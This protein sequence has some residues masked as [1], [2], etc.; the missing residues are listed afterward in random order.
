MSRWQKG[1]LQEMYEEACVTG[2]TKRKSKNNFR[3]SFRLCTL[4]RYSDA[5]RAL[6]EEEFCVDDESFES[7]CNLHPSKPDGVQTRELSTPLIITSTSIIKDCL[8]S[9]PKGSAPGLDGYRAEHILNAI[10]TVQN[11]SVLESLMALLNIIL[12]GRIHPEVKEWFAGGKLCALKKSDGGIRPI[13]MGSVVRRLTSKIVCRIY[14]QKFTEFLAPTQLG[15]GVKSG[16]ECL[17]HEVDLV[18]RAHQ[19]DKNFVIL[20]IDYRNAFNLV[21]RQVFLDSIHDNFPELYNYVVSMYGVQAILTFGSKCIR[22][23]EGTQQGDPMGPVLFSLAL[24]IVTDKLKKKLPKLTMNRWYLDDGYIGSKVKEVISAFKIVRDVGESV[25]LHLRIEKCELFYPAGEPVKLDSFPSKVKLIKDG[26]EVIGA[27]IGSE[28]FSNAFFNHQYTELKSLLQRLKDASSYLGTQSTFIL[29]SKCISFCR[30]VFHARTVHPSLLRTHTDNYDKLVQDCFSLLIPGLTE[31][32]LIQCSLP[33]REGGLGLRRLS[34]HLLPA[35]I[36]SAADAI[37]FMNIEETSVEDYWSLKQLLDCYNAAA[38]TKLTWKEINSQKLLSASIDQ[39][40]LSEFSSTL[41]GTDKH[42][43]RA[44]QGSLSSLWLSAVPTFRNQ[45]TSSE[46]ETCVK[47]RLGCT[48]FKDQFTCNF[49]GGNRAV[50]CRGHHALVCRGGGDRISRHNVIRDLLADICT[51]ASISP[52]SIV[53]EKKHLLDD[54]GARPADVFIPAWNEGRGLCLDITVSSPLQSV[55]SSNYTLGIAAIKAAE[56]KDRKYKD[57][58]TSKGI[59]FMPFSIESFGVM[60][61]RAEAFLNKVVTRL[62]T[63]SELNFSIVKAD[64]F[65]RVSIALHRSVAR[66]VLKRNKDSLTVYHAVDSR[67]LDTVFPLAQSLSLS[68]GITSS[69]SFISD[70]PSSSP[71]ASS[72]TNTSTATKKTV[73][74]VKKKVWIKKAHPP[75]ST[76]PDNSSHKLDHAVI[77][78]PD[79]SYEEISFMERI[80]NVEKQALE[81]HVELV[82]VNSTLDTAINQ[83]HSAVYTVGDFNP[84]PIIQNRPCDIRYDADDKYPNFKPRNIRAGSSLKVITTVEPLIISPVKKVYEVKVKD[85]GKEKLED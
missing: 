55:Y 6:E 70:L 78:P 27:P 54:S 42:R 29:L 46:F 28:S 32:Q 36:S 39:F 11:V 20:K 35:F 14:Q 82:K 15:V 58:C 51:E 41:V 49:C 22:S 21:D 63:R 8:T 64:V 66:S 62:A 9:F 73:L 50:D 81:A 13:C 60:D 68:S 5:L 45:L 38:N 85:K 25:G 19:S 47:L 3:R 65:R 57:K 12:S 10:N 23:E 84:N 52:G 7:L 43:F 53:T 18:Y 59:D 72:S 83:I 71:S 16:A 30:M 74:A 77:P 26:I 80:S 79:D 34:D 1:E 67:E 24:K 17:I 56:N 40:R 44:I 31:D 76:P 48:I 75:A 2:E 4:G 61:E 37:K 69:A 33:I